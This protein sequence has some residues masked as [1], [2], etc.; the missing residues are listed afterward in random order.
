M[1]GPRKIQKYSLLFHSGYVQLGCPEESSSMQDKEGLKQNATVHRWEDCSRLCRQRVGC[2][3]W[4]WYDGTSGHWAS[5][6]V[7]M[8]S[9]NRK[10]K[11]PGAM[12]GDRN[13]GAD[14]SF[15]NEPGGT[16]YIIDFH[17]QNIPLTKRLLRQSILGQQECRCGVEYQHSNSGGVDYIVGGAEVDIVSQNS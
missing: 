7:T 6:C 10:V 17:M 14:S 2:R 15:Q 4:T 9:A 5:R 12:S 8:T 3:Y 16:K 1:A 13:C 11:D